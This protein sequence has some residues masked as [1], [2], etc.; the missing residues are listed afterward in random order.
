MNLVTKLI[1]ANNALNTKTRAKT[2]ELFIAN[3]GFAYYPNSFRKTW[4]VG[5]YRLKNMRWLKK[6][7]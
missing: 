4:R 6:S 5:I 2:R 3:G 1:R 7:N